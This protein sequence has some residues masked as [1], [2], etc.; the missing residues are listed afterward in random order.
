MDTR[1]PEK[2]SE[3]M[4]LVRGRN[5]TPELAVRRLIHRLGYRFRLHSA[6][7]P[8]RPDIVLPRLR[9]AIFV[10]GCF[11]HGHEGCAKGRPPKSRTEYW[12]AKFDANR[13][14]DARNLLDLKSR[15]WLPLVVW[16][17]ELK[18][19][20]R[21]TTKVGKFLSRPKTRIAARKG[22]Q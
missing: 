5:T 13:K 12:K 2:R 8:G 1:T 14:R 20:E 3:I 22:K 21:L 17:C 16:Q 9:K 18:K 7:L 11:W 15:G 10:H 4:S 19:V 6:E